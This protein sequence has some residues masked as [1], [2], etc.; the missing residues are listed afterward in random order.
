MNDKQIESLRGIE[1]DSKEHFANIWQT[2]NA[3]DKRDYVGSI[4][5]DCI[6]DMGQTKTPRS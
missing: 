1:Q 2:L 5:W 3:S 6:E 4:F